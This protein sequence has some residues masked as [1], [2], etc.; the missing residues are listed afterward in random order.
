MLA[1]Q[2]VQRFAQTGAARKIGNGS[3]GRGPAW[4]RHQRVGRRVSN[5]EA[6]AKREHIP[7]PHAL[8][9]LPRRAV[10]ACKK[11]SSRRA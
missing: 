8:P 3:T 10:A 1:A 4:R 9:P 5:R 6:R 7:S 11:V 2:L